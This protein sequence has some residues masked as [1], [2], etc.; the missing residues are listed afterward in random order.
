[1]KQIKTLL[2]QYYKLLYKHFYNKLYKQDCSK[3]HQQLVNKIK[4]IGAILLTNYKQLYTYEYMLHLLNINHYTDNDDKVIDDITINLNKVCDTLINIMLVAIKYRAILMICQTYK[5]IDF[6]GMLPREMYKGIIDDIFQQKTV[7]DIYTY[8]SNNITSHS[9]Y[10]NVNTSTNITDFDSFFTYIVDSTW[11][12]H[13]WEIIYTFAQKYD[14]L[15]VYD[16]VPL[17]EKMCDLNL[18][19]HHS[20][21]CGTLLTDTSKPDMYYFLQSMTKDQIDDATKIN[22]KLVEKELQKMVGY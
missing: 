11:G 21:H 15:S 1:M 2:T 3:T 6:N 12:I 13:E 4:K 8:M 22:E 20:H 18:L 17:S 14:K 9:Q 7:S 5:Y 19:K 10:I 16:S